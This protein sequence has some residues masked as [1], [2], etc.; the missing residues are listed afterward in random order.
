MPR[1]F[2]SSRLYLRIPLNAGCCSADWRTLPYCLKSRVFGEFPYRK[3]RSWQFT[4]NPVLRSR[5]YVGQAPQRC[6]YFR[7]GDDTTAM[8]GFVSNSKMKVVGRMN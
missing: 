8:L 3:G 6:D 2:F 1:S 4:Y 5:R 7:I